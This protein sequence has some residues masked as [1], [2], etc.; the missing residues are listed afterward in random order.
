VDPAAPTT[1][2]LGGTRNGRVRF[3]ATRKTRASPNQRS[4]SQVS[5]RWTILCRSRHH[6]SMR[7][8]ATM[9]QV[10][11]T[12]RKSQTAAKSSVSTH[13]GSGPPMVKECPHKAKTSTRM[14]A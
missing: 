11:A 10:G 4:K 12:T 9:S 7:S 8:A 5:V 3:Q 6:H 13:Q 14:T 1:F 2:C